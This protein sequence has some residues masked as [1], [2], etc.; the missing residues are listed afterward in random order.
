MPAYFNEPRRKATQDA[1]RLAGLQVIDIIN[2]PTAAAIAFGVQEGFLSDQ[3]VARYRERILVYDLGGGTFDATLME[4][5]GRRFQTLAT[6][7]DVHLGGI[8]W[9]QRLADYL[10]T[11]FR[12]THGIDVRQDAIAAQTL[13]AEAE[14][15]KRALTTRDAVDIHLAFDG[16]RL[17]VH[18]T[19]EIFEHMTEDLVARTSFT[20]NKLLRDATLEWNDVTR[21]LMVGGS[22][23]MPMIQKMLRRESGQE[24]DRSL[25][26]DEAVAH[27]A[28]I[29]ADLLLNSADRPQIDVT[30]VNSHHL[31]VLGVE[32]GTGRPRTRDSDPPQHAAPG[33]RRGEVRHRQGESTQCGGESRGRRRCQRSARHPDRQMR[34]PRSAAATARRHQ[35]GS[36]VSLHSRRPLV[37]QSLVTPRPKRSQPDDRAGGGH[38][39]QRDPVVAAAHCRRFAARDPG[40][41]AAASSG[42]QRPEL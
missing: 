8:D 5:S 10:A 27:G 19:R 15:A 6:A 36:P 24:P 39:R 14:D 4:L 7:G 31:G 26:P 9:N 11:T 17:G 35:C 21:V 1:G 34:G 13:L 32:K 3:A 18:V 22:T 42:R 12:E 30:N 33:A 40:A 23:R 38:V 37:G 2:E 16:R 20:I 41:D 28:A 25:S 29:Y